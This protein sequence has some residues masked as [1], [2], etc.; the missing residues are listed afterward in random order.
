LLAVTGAREAREVDAAH[1]VGADGNAAG[2]WPVALDEPVPLPRLRNGA[3]APRHLAELQDAPGSG[4]GIP[5]HAEHVDREARG[6]GADVEPDRPS[7]L[8]ARGVGVS[9]DLVLQCGIDQLPVGGPWPLVLLG[10]GIG[11]AL[12]VP[13]TNQKPTS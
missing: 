3:L 7:R 10:G 4:S 12:R 6:G 11:V 8:R 2:D 1:P 13:R 9:L 5:A